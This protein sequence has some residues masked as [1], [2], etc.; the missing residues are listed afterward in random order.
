MSFQIHDPYCP[1]C[2]ETEFILI[3]HKKYLKSSSVK[4]P[5]NLGVYSENKDG[6]TFLKDYAEYL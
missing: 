3:S 1:V 4:P 5:I 6:I 2:L